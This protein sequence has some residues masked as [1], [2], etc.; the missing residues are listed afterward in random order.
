MRA[1]L[2]ALSLT[3]LVAASMTAT[4]AFNY[5]ALEGRTIAATIVQEDGAYIAIASDDANYACMVAYTNGKID[6]TW[7]GGTGCAATTGSGINPHSTYYY[8]DVLKITNKGTKTWTGLWLNMTD[9]A[10]T[11]NTKAVDNGMD[12]D[13]TYAQNVYLTT[14]LAPGNVWYVGYKID[15]STLTTASSPSKTMTIA[16]R[17]SE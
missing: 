4:S 12:T 15:A 11:I 8:H 1:P 13:D 5:A 9:T 17:A 10:I 6:V 7:D 3:A 2:I 16:A 14:N